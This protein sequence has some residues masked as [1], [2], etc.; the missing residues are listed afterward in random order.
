MFVRTPITVD[1][2]PAPDPSAGV[3]SP[4]RLCAIAEGMLGS[5][6][7]RIAA[8]VR[9]Q[10]AAGAR[11][12]NLTVGDF[13]PSE[14]R[15]PPTLE[16]R[17]EEALRAGQTN[18]PP[19]EGVPELRASVRDFY[20]DRLGLEYP[21]SSVLVA[22]GARPAIYAAF[23]TLVDPGDRVVYATPSWN[24]D[25]YCHLV[26]AVPV[27]VACDA[28][29]AFLPTR[30]VLADAVRGARMLALN[31]PLNPTGTAFDPDTLAGICDLVL[32][33][34]ARRG[35]NER[36]LYLLYDQVYWLLTFGQTEHVD[37]VSLR[38]EIAPYVLLV[39]AISKP[40][41]A[42]GLR[43]GWVVGPTDIIARMSNFIGHV[44]AWAPR[45]E[46][47]ATAAFLQHADEVDEYLREIRGGVEQ[48]L[49]ALYDSLSAMRES[50]LP[51]EVIPPMGAIYLTVRFS[52]LGRTTP[53]GQTLRTNDDIRH[54]LLRAAGFAV[55]PF[56]AFGIPEDT[57]WFRMSTGAVSL[58]DIEDAMPRLRAA[59]EAV[60]R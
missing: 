10:L 54:Y 6:I 49:D 4:R 55:V 56:Q 30:E 39:D 52:L 26:G 7:L 23:A 43:V 20:R 45:A 31:S 53:D 57:A 16:R 41:A 25:H 38:P 21:V 33:E 47:I 27:P 13:R 34:N 17:I 36:P 51:V 32:E 1:A 37:P 48:R 12:C 18:Y 50:G 40:F 5:Q 42:T 15:L 58:A 22:S 14:F 44:G 9:A 35:T 24:N 19:A 28:S 8:D 3:H 29:T 60:G 2:S 46:Q 11:I 59:L